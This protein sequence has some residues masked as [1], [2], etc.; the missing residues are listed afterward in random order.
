MK[1][2]L[3][4]APPA[5]WIGSSKTS[6]SSACPIRKTAGQWTHAAIAARLSEAG[7]EV[8]QID[9]VEPSLEDVYNLLAHL[10][11]DNPD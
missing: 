2:V 10:D 5:S 6:I 7:I 8:A 9:A 4:A 11:Q 1:A 3:P